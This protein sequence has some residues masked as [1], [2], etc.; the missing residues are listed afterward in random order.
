MRTP[1]CT[2][3][4]DPVS[5]SVDPGRF[6]QCVHGRRGS[7][8]ACSCRR[9]ATAIQGYD[10]VL[11]AGR[12][13]PRPLPPVT[14]AWPAAAGTARA[15]AG[16]DP[17]RRRASHPLSPHPEPDVSLVVEPDV[18]RGQAPGIHLDRR[19]TP[20]EIRTVYGEGWRRKSSPRGRPAGRPATACPRAGAR[21][22]LGPPGRAVPDGAGAHQPEIRAGLAAPRLRG[23][24]RSEQ[25]GCAGHRW[26]R[27]HRQR[28]GARLA[29]MAAARR[30]E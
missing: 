11:E 28:G 4:R 10:E 7:R 1:C 5:A 9:G 23:P 14:P 22:D 15:P 27:I 30:H 29:R 3:L 24:C 2:G 19:G 8:A 17:T 21:V 18:P 16:Y 12:R 6:C 13:G 20:G 25:D 26:H